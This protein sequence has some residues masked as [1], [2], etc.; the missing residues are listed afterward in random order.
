MSRG[1]TCR[2]T[3]TTLADFEGRDSQ[4]SFSVTH[5]WSAFGRADHGWQDVQL[6]VADA[7]VPSPG[8]TLLQGRSDDY[9]HAGWSRNV[10]KLHFD[11]RQPRPDCR[12]SNWRGSVIG[13]RGHFAIGQRGRVPLWSNLSPCRSRW[14]VPARRIQR[15]LGFDQLALLWQILRGG[16]PKS[17]FL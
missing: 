3:S 4:I 2:S 9:S 17:V 12:R 14:Q 11:P 15:R 6:S 10:A 16:I 13:Y 8:S 1:R 7:N 5:G